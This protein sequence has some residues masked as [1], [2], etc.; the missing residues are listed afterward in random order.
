MKPTEGYFPALRAS[1]GDWWF[2]IATMTMKDVAERVKRVDAIHETTSLKTWIQREMNPK[3]TQQI[4]DYLLTQPQR[5]FNAVVLGI[6]GGSP[7]WFPV[8]VSAGKIHAKVELDE[9]VSTAFG[10]IKLSGEEELFAIDGQHRIEGIKC[11]IANPKSGKLSEEEQTVILV[12][13]KMTDLGRQR[14]R[15]LFST[16]N[17]YA[18]PVSEG[19]LIALSEDDTFAIV[20]RKLVDEYTGL[21]GEF[22]PLHKTANL[23]VSDKRSLTSVIS[24]YA[25]VRA[26]SVPSGKRTAS[27]LIV[28]PPDSAHVESFYN[29]CVEFWDALKKHVREVHSVCNSKPDQELAAKYRNIEGGHFLFRPFCLVAFAKATRILHDRGESIS[30]AVKTLAKANMDL[31]QDPWLHV[32]WNP[33]KRVMMNRN[34]PLVRNLLLHEAGQPLAPGSFKLREKYLEALGE[35]VT[36]YAL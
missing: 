22:V 29:Q 16:L 7:D 2:Y 32:V 4:A 24:L 31:A 14:T 1:I 30:D 18:K 15:R 3:R 23:P 10:L 21:S 6:Y 34:E 27:H 25:V 9:R 11:A 19:E 17:R 36:T 13:H 20:T 8:T 28:G 12:A 26:L 33:S 5:F 35:A